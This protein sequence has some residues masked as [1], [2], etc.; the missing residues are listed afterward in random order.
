MKVSIIGV[1]RVGSATAFKLLSEPKLNEITLIDIKEELLEG[2]YLDLLHS[3]IGMESKVKLNFSSKIEDARDSDLIIITAGVA[4]DPNVKS[5]LDLAEINSKIIKNICEKIKNPKKNHIVLLMTNPV[6]LM[7]YVAMKTLGYDKKRVIGIGSEL[8]TMRFKV[9]CSNARFNLGE[10]GDSMVFV[11][12][13]APKEVKEYTR[14]I[15]K[16]IINLKGGTWWGPST[17]LYNVANSIINDKK[18]ERIVSTYLNGE[19]G[20]N[21]VCLSLPSKIG[22]NGIENISE[23]NLSDEEIKE[24]KKSAE[25]LEEIKTK[26]E[27]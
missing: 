12:N 2:E 23:I 17:A 13:D 26:I 5:R 14:K 3:A 9:H 15:S 27:V 1:G 25:I 11:P 16:K 7:T 6:D 24:L 18:N 10:H 8:D 4:R 22:I 20:I 21:D 19:Y